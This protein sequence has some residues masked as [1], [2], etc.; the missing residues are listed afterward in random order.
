MSIKIIRRTGSG[1]SWVRN[2]LFY[3]EFPPE[4]IEFE[5]PSLMW[6]VYLFKEFELIEATDEN[7]KEL[8]LTNVRTCCS[9]AINLRVKGESIPEPIITVVDIDMNTNIDNIEE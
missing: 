1:V 4:E 2:S 5:I 9:E 3:M 6:M 8:D 7:G